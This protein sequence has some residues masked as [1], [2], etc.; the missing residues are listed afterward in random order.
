MLSGAVEPAGALLVVCFQ[1]LVV[2]LLP[3]F[4]SFSA[5]AM[6]YVVVEE[7]IPAAHLSKHSDAGTLA[8]I[9]GFIL[10]MTL[11]TALG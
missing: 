3:W 7:L 9:T 11:D 6:L 10:M 1:D 4:L 2:S 5:G 8:V